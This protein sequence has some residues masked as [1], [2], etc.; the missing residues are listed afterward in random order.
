MPRSPSR[1]TSRKRPVAR[2]SSPA[3][4]ITR[5]LALFESA[6]EGPS[7]HGPSV[8]EAL[9]GVTASQAAAR[10]IAHAHTIGELVLHMATWKRAVANRIAGRP[11]SPSAAEN[12]PEFRARDW[13]RARSTLRREHRALRAVLSRLGT[14]RLSRPAVPGGSAV[15]L[16]AHGV[17]HHDLWHAGQIMTLRRALETAKSGRR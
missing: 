7:W 2:A 3:G 4:E 12:F 16:Q 11:Y 9:K 5:L 14:A 15:Y 6:F 8:R 13:T 17:V 1:R 10:P